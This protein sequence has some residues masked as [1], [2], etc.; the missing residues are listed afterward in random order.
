MLLRIE[1]SKKVFFKVFEGYKVLKNYVFQYL[2]N[3][4]KKFPNWG[5]GQRPKF[6]N[7]YSVDK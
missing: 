7:T 3:F 4:F 2:G 6:V 5:L 1:R